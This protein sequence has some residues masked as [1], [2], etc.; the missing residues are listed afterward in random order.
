MLNAIDVCCGCGG[1]AEAA[2]GLPIRITHVFDWAEDCLRTYKLNHPDVECVQCDVV[3]H[4]FT[5]YGADL[6]L[7]GIPCEPVS[8]VRNNVPLRPEVYKVWLGLIEKCLAIP[9]QVGA[10]WWCYEDIPQLEKHLPILTPFFALDSADFSGQR[11]KRI[12][13][14]NLPRPVSAGDRRVL[15]DYVLPGPYRLSAGLEGRQPARSYCYRPDTFYPWELEE[16]SPTVIQ[17]TSRHDN[18][19]AIRH[20]S[21]WRQV[22]WKEQAGLQGFRDDYIFVGSPGRV[23]KMVAQA[24]QI[25]TAR[26]IL[27]ALCGE[28][29]LEI[30]P[31]NAQRAQGILVNGADGCC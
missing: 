5:G 25:D 3:E 28:L 30:E 14:G 2:R 15:R 1:W 27:V 13:V 29:Q 17:L 11:R 22:D 21:G 20:G 7:G 9:E 31:Q 10:R 24:V 18:Y 4:D 23:E 26:A 8:V 19:A 16:K 12:Y 6:V